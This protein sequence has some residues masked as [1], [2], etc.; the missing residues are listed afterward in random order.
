ME[1][2]G[3]RRDA[4]ADLR[5][6]L[7]ALGIRPASYD[8]GNHKTLCPQCSHTRKNKRDPCLSL[9]IGP[10]STARGQIEDGEAVYRCHNCELSG[11]VRHRQHQDRPREPRDRK[12]YK[13]PAFRPK[14]DPVLPEAAL[15]WFRK[16][17]ISKATLVRNKV[18]MTRAWMPQAGKEIAVTAFPYLRGGE[19]VN[20]KYRGPG[21]TFRQEKDAEKIFYGLDNLEPDAKEVIIVEGE[22]DSLAL[23]EAGFWNVLS[24]PDG[25]PAQARGDDES[26]DPERD[27]KFE[28]VWNCRD[29]LDA[30][31]RVILAVDAD[32][33]GQAL[34][35]ELSRR[36]GRE[37]CWRVRWPAIND[38]QLKDANEVLVQEGAEVLRECVAGAQPYPI[39]SLFE[40]GQFE[41]DVLRLF[42]GPQRGLSTGWYEVDRFYTVRPG[43]LT[44]VS[45]YPSSGKSAWVDSLAINL[46]QRHDWKFAFASFENPPAEHLGKW[47]QTLHGAPFH[48]GPRQRMTRDELKWAVQ[49][50]SRRFYLIRSDDEAPTIE[51][52][53]EKARAAVMRYGVQGLVIDPYNEIE[54][55]RL[56]GESETDYISR[57]LTALKKFA[58]GH[59]VHVWI[60]AHPAKPMRTKAGGYLR[61]TLYDIAASA[62]WRNKA[63]CG[64]ILHREQ[65]DDGSLSDTV[66]VYVDKIRFSAVGRIG[67]TKLVYSPITGRYSEPDRQAG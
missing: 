27:A 47:A 8:A 37:K 52:L 25:A 56:P 44:V 51:W 41:T 42:D 40:A 21:K 57:I 54:H 20:V 60:V 6:E 67:R 32:G 4:M 48:D 16:R 18:S 31:E 46:A 38:V 62:N 66:G 29:V 15:A 7:P 24:V 55:R 12:A 11:A 9:T 5:V 58:A 28:Y 49:W 33:P 61:P 22:G 45:G 30:A 64:I 59:G 19:V 65:M 17:G 2:G 34:E 39:R 50:L 3:H 26:I 1:R 63:D 10:A 43:E 13:R 23:N 14:P 53:L 35:A 36:I